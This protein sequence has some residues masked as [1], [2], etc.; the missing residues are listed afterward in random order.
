[1]GGGFRFESNEIVDNEA[2]IL[3]S[4]ERPSVCLV[5]PCFNEEEVLPETARRL[6]VLIRNLKD[7]QSICDDSMICF[8]DDGSLDNTW[9]IIKGLSEVYS[10][11]VGIK[12]SANRGHQNALFCGL[13]HCQGDLV[14]SLDVDLQDDINI[15]PEMIT[16][17][18]AGNEIVYGV[19]GSRQSDSY[20][21]R[22]TAEIYYHALKA[23]GVRVVF[24]HADYRLLSRTA[25]ES[26]REFKEDHLFLR[27]M[28]PLL[29]FKADTV[30]FERAKRFAGESKYP[31][32]KMLALAWQG[33]T[34]FSAFPLRLITSA[35]I[36]VSFVSIALSVWAL[37]VTLFTDKAV[38]GWASSVIPM[39]FLGGIQLLGLGV[40]GEYVAKIYEASKNRPRYIIEEVAGQKDAAHKDAL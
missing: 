3:V 37:S 24:N 30:I 17:Y 23:L 35:G 8:V 22:T 31:L 12:L 4:R 11:V 14:I 1:M 40:M 34:S 7:Q 2:L 6:L 15:I 21:K 39:Y 5:L 19:R 18:K 38:P 28:I 36:F 9:S 10:E 20:F 26:L 16:K 29:G 32:R 25:L 13:M 27:G 33:V